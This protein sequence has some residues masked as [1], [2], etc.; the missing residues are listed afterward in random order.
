MH[1]PDD[2]AFR[3]K[4]FQNVS[5]AALEPTDPRYEPL[6]GNQSL[7]AGEADPVELMAW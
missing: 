2:A 1:E 4:F 5:D 3:R 6:Y 7:L